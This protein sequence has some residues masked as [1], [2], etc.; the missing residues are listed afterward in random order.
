MKPLSGDCWLCVAEKRFDVVFA[1]W[2]G[3]PVLIRWMEDRK[4]H[5]PV[6]LAGDMQRRQPAKKN[7]S[8]VEAAPPAASGVNDDPW[9]TWIANKGGTGICLASAI[10]K[11]SNAA[12]PPRK[13]ESPIEDRFTRHD[14]A[15]QDYKQHTEQELDTLKESIARIERSIDLQNTNIQANLEMTNAE[16]KSIRSETASQLQALTGAFTESLRSTIASQEDQMSQQFAELKEMIMAS[17]VSKSS[18]SPPQKKSKKN[19]ADDN[20]L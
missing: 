11:P 7:D 19:G 12:L 10:P 6:I 4:E 2:N 15:L 14:T 5:S 18:A 17:S 1:Q 8:L 9:G 13:L 16:F 20:D 3:N